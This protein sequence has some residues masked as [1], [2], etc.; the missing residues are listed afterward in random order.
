MN[1]LVQII[2]AVAALGAA[3][4]AVAQ[5]VVYG[6]SST[7]AE[8]VLQ[9][10]G[11]AKTFESRSGVKFTIADTSGTGK[12]L[13]ALADGKINL[14]G[15]GR[16]L[17]AEER[18]AGLLGTIIG[19]DGLA[20]YVNRNNPVKALTRAQLKDLFIGRVKSWKEL[21]GR[22]VPVAPIIEPVASKRATV[23][24]F[25]EQVLDGASFKPGIREMEQ[26]GEQLAEVAASEGAVCVAS[27]GFMASA[28]AGVKGAVKPLAIDGIEPGDANIQ[29]GAY[30]LSRPVLLVTKGLPQGDVKKFIDFVRSRDG[31][32]IVEKFFVPVKR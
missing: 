30:L 14:V 17:A 13:K 4:A 32:Q 8:T 2:A 18:K 1:R 3:R 11:A 28:P 29:S 19:Y 26:L 10:G 27:I 25:Q 22:D 16:T 15:S 5:G 6:G 7:I 9:G 20:V 12:G 21:G 24:L 23:Q 31:Q